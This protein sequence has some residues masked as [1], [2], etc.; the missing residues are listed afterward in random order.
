MKWFPRVGGGLRKLQT[1]EVR[2]ALVNQASNEGLWDMSVIAGDPINP[3]NEFWWSDQFRKMLGYQGEADFPNVLDSWASK[4]HPEDK[5]QV[6]QAFG[7]HLTDYTAR[8]PYDIEYR[9][10]TKGRG[11]R[12]FRA[13]GTTLRDPRGM[14]L[15]VAGSLADITEQKRQA[16][17]TQTLQTRF[18][19]VNQAS[20]DG[21][22]DMSVIAGDPINPSNEFWWS[23]QFRKMLGYQGEADFPNVLD[24]WASKLHPE[25]KEQV[26]QAF[27]AHL[28]DYTARTPYDIEYRLLTKGRGY[29]WFRAR[30]TTLRDPK[31][32]PL[33]VAGSLADI[34]VEKQRLLQAQSI[35]EAASRASGEVAATAESL[36]AG[37]RSQTR[38][39]QQNAAALEEMLR[40]LTATS[41]NALQ[42]TQTANEAGATAEAGG[43]VVGKTIHGMNAIAGVVSEAASKVMELGQSSQRV[44]EIVGVI[45][46]IAEQ[47]NLLAL[48]AAIEA[49]RA[50]SEGRGFAV[51]ADE[52]RKLA[53]HTA[54][55]TREIASVIAQIQKDTAEA[56]RSIQQGKQEVDK[57]KELAAQAEE[58]LSKIIQAARQVDLI[59]AQVATASQQQLATSEQLAQSTQVISEITKANEIGLSGMVT[60]SAD[61][62]GIIKDLLHSLTG[63]GEEAPAASAASAK[64]QAR[65]FLKMSA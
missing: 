16:L 63:N 18:E 19:L 53:E 13:R 36:A 21:L 40:S 61:I 50:G 59:I 56:L 45:S 7:A 60:G 37:A 57:G 65:G 38:Q 54:V 14:P 5:E 58:S 22:W 26:L 23:D 48:N 10:L 43:Q 12:W 39:T 55:S 24:S 51:V 35:A 15:R 49:A 2:F 6:L 41:R 44:G 62:D 3:S 28:T 64:P 8:T 29:R 17:E 20:S 4:L 32:M 42:A 31:G 33:R 9:L 34:T 30:G 11:Y 1:L 52:V 27:G 25:D 47:T 46:S